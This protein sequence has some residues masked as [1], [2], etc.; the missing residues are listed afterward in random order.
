MPATTLEA[1]LHATIGAL[2]SE[3]V[4]IQAAG[5][6]ASPPPASGAQARVI[7]ASP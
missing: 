7:R 6:A 1:R 3:H 2:M 4:S 5:F